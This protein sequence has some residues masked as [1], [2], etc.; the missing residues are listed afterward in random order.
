MPINGVQAGNNV[1]PKQQKKN[2]TLGMIAAGSGLGLV[3][4]GA[5][6]YTRNL[7]VNKDGFYT[8]Q[9]VARVAKGFEKQD[10]EFKK[11][12]ADTCNEFDDLF[13][14]NQQEVKLTAAQKKTLSTSFN[15]DTQK[16]I[17]AELSIPDLDE[18]KITEFLKKHAEMLEINP[19]SGETIDVAVKRYIDEQPRCFLNRPIWQDENVDTFLKSVISKVSGKGDKAV[20]V[21]K[22]NSFHAIRAVINIHLGLQ[23]DNLRQIIGIHNDFDCVSQYMDDFFDRSA[24][25]FKEVSESIPKDAMDA[26][27]KAAKEVNSTSAKFKNAAMFGGLAA[28]VAGTAASIS[29]IFI[30][31]NS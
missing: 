18:T 14:N 31:K 17:L 28:L 23:Q 9:F 30:N 13:F 29:S 20:R 25:K 24:K 26:V 21:P 3:G 22:D 5:Y 4:G 19:S 2:N 11:A 16:F 8:D 6:G 1:Q 15:E 12:L 7:L 27:K 10:E